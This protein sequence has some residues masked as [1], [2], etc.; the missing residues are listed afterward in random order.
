MFEP[1]SVDREL[2]AVANRYQV[3]TLMELC[4]PAAQ[5]PALGDFINTFFLC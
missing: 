3:E 4:R 5:K 2:F 1:S